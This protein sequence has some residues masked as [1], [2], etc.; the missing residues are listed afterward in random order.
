MM[1]SIADASF[2]VEVGGSDLISISLSTHIYVPLSRDVHIL[3]P[4]KLYQGR[5]GTWKRGLNNEAPLMK[6]LAVAYAAVYRLE[7]LYL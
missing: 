2:H 5:Y 7:I 6:E 3:A 4:P 1:T